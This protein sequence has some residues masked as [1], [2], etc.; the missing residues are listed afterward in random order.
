[1]EESRKKQILDVL[2]GQY[3]R[4]EPHDNSLA[5]YDTAL[6]HSSFANDMKQKGIKCEDYERL[7]FFGNYL[8]DFVIADHL[9]ATTKL[10][11]GE[12]NKRIQVTENYNLA[13]IVMKYDLGIDDAILLSKGTAL[14]DSIIADTFEAL[15]GAIF[16]DINLGKA[17]EVILRIF[18][19]E[20]ENV[21]EDKNAKGLLQEYIQSNQLMRPEYLYEKFGPDDAPKWT[22]KVLIGGE[23]YGEGSGQRKRE[24]AMYAAREALKKLNVR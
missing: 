12:M 8:L 21:S 18:T 3:F 23:N 16:Y 14:T 7:E 1:M 20:I 19:A 13:D 9:Y 10:P 22:A 15:I 2:S 6:T 11:E 24:A 4:I 17:K 5:L